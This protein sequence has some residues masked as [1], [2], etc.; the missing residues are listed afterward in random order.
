MNLNPSNRTLVAALLVGA[1][2]AAG[3]VAACSSS[4]AGPGFTGGDDASTSSGGGD[5]GGSVSTQPGSCSNSTIGITFAPMYSAY[6]PGSTAQ[7]FAI[8]AVT[9]DGNAA[10]WSLSD[11]TQANMQAQSFS[12]NGTTQP[13][14][15]ITIAGTGD[16]QG[17]VTVI[18]TESGGAC[19]SA[20]LHIT[21]NSE[22]DW[23]IGNA[24]YNDGVALHLGGTGGGDGGGGGGGF[25]GAFP[26]GGFGE[27]GFPHGDA[28][29]FHTSDGG[30]F[31]EQ[32]G[33]TACTNCHGPTATAMNSPFNDVSHTPEQTGGFSDT[34]LQ[35]II[36]N[37]EIPDG[38]YFDPT[39]LVKT[40]DG[41]AACTAQAYAEWHSF[42]QWSDITMDELPGII[43][44]LRALTP[45]SQNGTSNFGGGGG[46]HHGDGGGG[47]HH[48]G[49][50][51]GGQ[52]PAD[53]SAGD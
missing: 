22:N 28:G 1:S 37:G 12:A 51:G 25:D 27:G 24:R 53:G 52:P 13:G 19:G 2:C 43:C 36:L 20:V 5:S 46:G 8:P 10:Q 7:T 49:G 11:P 17:N 35:N 15:M 30:S 40:C 45:E 50:G 9:D 39:V 42:H 32:D 47:G 3:A 29:G 44:Y 33:G 34:D 18:A 21:T 23:T 26:E 14:V 31:F 48:D 6:I 16:S 38:G 4:S 41:G